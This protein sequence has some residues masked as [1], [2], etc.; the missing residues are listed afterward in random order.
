MAVD[1]DL[2]SRL[3]GSLA[4]SAQSNDRASAPFLG[5]PLVMR[6]G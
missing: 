6:D 5:I 1:T 2:S 3:A 4:G